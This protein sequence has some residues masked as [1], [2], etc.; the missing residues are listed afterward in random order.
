MVPFWLKRWSYFP[1]SSRIKNSLTLSFSPSLPLSLGL[2]HSLTLVLQSPRCG[3]RLKWACPHHELHLAYCCAGFSMWAQIDESGD[4]WLSLMIKF[5][6]Y[7]KLRLKYR[8]AQL[9]AVNQF[10]NMWYKHKSHLPILFASKLVCPLI[11]YC[12]GWT[13]PWLG[14]L[15]LYHSFIHF[16]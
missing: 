8:P 10:N 11:C 15:W 12:S 9:D 2:S 14:S 1:C 13:K 5:H 6:R 3:G 7:Q 16:L 4:S